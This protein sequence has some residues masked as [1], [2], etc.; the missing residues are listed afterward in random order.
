MEAL[1]ASWHRR[2]VHVWPGALER[3]HAAVRQIYR[4]VDAKSALI[5]SR[6]G[7][8]G[9]ETSR[10]LLGGV[11]DT[12][13]MT[14]IVGPALKVVAVACIGVKPMAVDEDVGDEYRTAE[15]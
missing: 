2:T 1:C 4:I 10:K 9:L 7:G 5:R 13:T 6:G 8:S 3:V 11:R 14:W 15:P 12:T